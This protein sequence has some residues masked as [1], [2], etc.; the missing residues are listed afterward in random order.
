MMA[1]AVPADSPDEDDDGNSLIA[2]RYRLIAVLGVGGMGVTYRAWDTQAGIPVV[3]KM[4]RPEV[5]DDSE[6]I[7]RFAREIDAMLAVP[8]EFI[9]PITDHGDDDGCPFVVMR[10]L[11]GGSLAESALRSVHRVKRVQGIER[12]AESGTTSRTHIAKRWE[13]PAH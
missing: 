9:V 4:P 6:A 10:F 1:I 8:H 11:P 13:A 3:I 7:Q 5:R 2:G 12:G